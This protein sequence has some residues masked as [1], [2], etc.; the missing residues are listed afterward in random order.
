MFK[1]VDP[2]INFPE[3]EKKWLKHWY[4]KGIDKKYRGKNTKSDRHFSF[5]DGPI[6]ANN[7]MGV[8]HAW[9]RT[10]KDL[11]PR[12]YNLLGYKQRFQNGFDCQGLW[13]EV[14][15]EKELGLHTKKDIENLVSGDKKASIAKFVQ[16]C[17]ERVM[18]FSGI[19]TEQS[20]RLGYFADWDNSYFTMSDENNYMIWYFLKK[21]YDQGWIYKGHESVP[22]CPRCETAISQHEMLTEDYKELVHQSVYFELPIIGRK[23]ENLLVWTTTPWTIP[24]NIAVAVDA[25]FDYSLVE[26]STGQ[27]F[28]IAKE[29]VKTVFKENFKI[30]KTVKGK[31]LVGLKYHGP[32]DDLPR[33]KEVADANPD[34]FHIV[35]ATDKMILPIT[36]TEGTGM[37][38]TAVSA[39]VEDFKMGK[40]LGLP[41]IPIIEDNADYMKGLGFLS[42]KNAKKHPEI[43]LD[44]LKNNL[45]QNG[46]SWVFAVVAYKHRYPACWRCKTELVWKVE[47]EWYIAMDKPFENK[48]LR[49]RMVEV[50][51][52]IKWMPEFGLD[53]ELD[54]LKNMHDWLISKKNRYWG[55]ALPIY[56]CK[57]CGYFEVIG[58]K[59]ELKE[60]SVSGF[61]KF[62][63]NTPHKPFI[64]EV[65]I[66]CRHCGEVITRIDDVGNPWL[67]AGIVAYSTISEG[68]KGEPLYNKDKKEWRKWFP[69][70]FITESFP[71]QFKN[72][73]YALIAESTVLENEPPFKRV[74]GF[75]TQLGE[76]GRPMHK[77]WGNAIE[78]NEGADKIGVDVMRWMFVRHNPADNM[79]FGY[80]KADEI[81]RQFYLMLWNVYKFFVEYANLDKF[82][83]ETRRSS[84]ARNSKNILD[85]W[86]LS[87]FASTIIFVEKSLKDFN[88]KDAALEI[89]K[90]VSDLSTW[91]I[92][93]SRDR[94]WVNSDNIEDKNNFYETLYYILVNLSVIISP[95]IPFVAEEIYINLTGK[96]SVNLENWPQINSAPTKSGQ[97]LELEKQMEAA[98]KIVEA[99][100]A[101]RKI[102]GVKVRIP[103]ANLNIKTE[104]P[105]NLESILNEVWE[106]VIKELNIKNIT[107]NGKFHYPKVTVEV[108]K[109]QLEKEGKL[110]ELIREIQSQRKLKNLRTDESIELVISGEFESK[111][112]FIAKRVLAKK[113][114]FGDKTEVQ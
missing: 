90:F 26:G 101:E 21:C 110:R 51:K 45:N 22:W 32:F 73:F 82:N 46:E 58:S 106:V 8:H 56:E 9:G 89:E 57:K 93:R 54:W 49:E 63:G 14:E 96:E 59:K 67:D 74:L 34:K 4:E 95:F 109:E 41:M 86:I 33:V 42:G 79:L 108:T 61:D 3:M 62:E 88:A 60:R 100:Q 36:T 94:V 85:K 47:D 84:S 69:A 80:K 70:D 24:A 30:L 43:I 11:W 7:P 48:T 81:R 72:W 111:K 31:E 112:D 78:F 29:L 44:Y 114:S 77:S 113:I 102:N 104:L 13:V 37:V 23:N 28:W 83:V 40:K 25:T 20:K 68:N 19:Q 12:F 99:G 76:D 87:R 91:F 27:K 17:K 50:T 98:R 35:F 66:K 65:K 52:K 5:L 75:G 2:K 1:L 71:G 105:V 15:V 39:G 103:L 64:D 97:N 55:L 107:V 38:H 6:T 18:K 16:L 10:Y 53:R 92:R